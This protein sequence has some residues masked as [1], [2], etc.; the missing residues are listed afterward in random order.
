MRIVDWRFSRPDRASPGRL[1]RA[2]VLAAAI[3]CF[4]APRA[5]AQTA[6][7]QGVWLIDRKVAIQVFDCADMV[8][9]R[10]LWLYKPRDAEGNLD[11]DK[12]NPDPL[13]RRRPLYGLTILWALRADGQ[14]RWRDGWFY[15]PD[16]GKTY[17][18]SAQLR[19]DDVLVARIYVGIPLFGKT[20]TMVRVPQGVTAGWR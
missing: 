8:C 10:I 5:E 18:V 17:R 3:I 7:P 1:F 4:G 2:A 6:V 16:D 14:R 13:L 15:N 11:L 20:K 9:G 19:S 12:N